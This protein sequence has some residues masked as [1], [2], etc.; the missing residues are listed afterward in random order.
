MNALFARLLLL[1]LLILSYS[2]FAITQ[3]QTLYFEGFDYELSL[4]DGGT[5]IQFLEIDNT[6][7]GGIATG[8]WCSNG[9]IPVRF[10]FF[11][12]KDEISEVELTLTFSNVDTDYSV[13]DT[14]EFT[15]VS[16]SPTQ[17]V[18]ELNIP[19]LPAYSSE[20]TLALEYFF[21]LSFGSNQTGTFPM[22]IVLEDVTE[23]EATSPTS[24]PILDIEQPLSIGGFTST[25]VPVGNES[26]LPP[27]PGNT[28]QGVTRI[29]AGQLLIDEDYTFGPGSK[30]YFAPGLNGYPAKITIES[31]ATLRVMEGSLLRACDDMWNTIEIKDGGKLILEDVTI[32][33]AESGVTIRRNGILDSR[34]TDFLDC[35]VGI[36][37]EPNSGQ[38]APNYI[39]LSVAG[40]SFKSS[41]PLRRPPYSDIVARAGMEMIDT[42]GAVTILGMPATSGFPSI[43]ARANQFENLANGIIVRDGSNVSLSASEFKDIIVSN[44]EL[45]GNGIF[46]DNN[47]T[48]LISDLEFVDFPVSFTRM[49]VG[50]NLQ[51]AGDVT[52][53]GI[54][55]QGVGTGIRSSFS[56]KTE[57]KNNTLDVEDIGIDLIGGFLYFNEVNDNQII[58]A[59]PS[60]S[61]SAIMA[62]VRVSSPFSVIMNAGVY[63]NQI[64]LEDG[65][66]GI[67]SN[68]S[69]QSDF[70][71]NHIFADTDSYDTKGIF[72]SGGGR[73]RFYNNLVV[74]PST[75]FTESIGL[76]ID[77]ES[78]SMVDCNGTYN[79]EVGFQFVKSNP[80]SRFRNN[81][82]GDAATGL[83]LGTE[84]AL[85]SI[86]EGIM[87]PQGT[88]IRHHAN[89]WDGTYT[90]IEARTLVTTSLVVLQSEF[91]VDSDDDP[92]YLA[93]NNATG[94]FVNQFQSSASLTTCQNYPPK[95]APQL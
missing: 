26:N 74:G 66:F 44:E 15:L 39:N 77:D 32:M 43:P 25:P 82:I 90:D 30:L 2:Q 29:F 31:G 94:W 80:N 63:D 6:P 36:L 40:N 20:E 16:S 41:G 95:Y 53:D 83:L 72:A 69:F 47:S 21:Y 46:I 59:N 70:Y 86:I 61:N 60:S 48:V 78:R 4:I 3:S 5:T 14:G 79:T 35:Y 23:G 7:D 93:A 57:I 89:I 88:D 38:T 56:F 75:A 8:S 22:S 71:G 65:E 42:R 87:G 49:P 28:T 13:E 33:D 50:I 62:G 68:G 84:D 9:L 17:T 11:P 67:L 34:R 92:D 24:I 37:S 10:V 64:V 51:R 18:Y 76:L 73:N 19:D 55:M 12:T 27:P 81:Y 85:G 52:I 1:C 54:E 45:S 58:V 91:K